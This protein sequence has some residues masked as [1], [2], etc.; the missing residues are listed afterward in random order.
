MEVK[1]CCKQVAEAEANVVVVLAQK[2]VDEAVS[3]RPPL[4]KHAS[5][6]PCRHGA[7][8][9][10]ACD[11]KQLRDGLVELVEVAVGVG[12]VAIV[13]QLAEHVVELNCVLGDPEETHVN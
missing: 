12:Y 1:H 5:C 13:V 8:C 11:S 6:D 4:A 7:N 3:L 9:P 2:P 10:L